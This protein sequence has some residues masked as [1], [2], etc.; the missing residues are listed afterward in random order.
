MRRDLPS[1]LVR[2]RVLFNLIL[3]LDGL[4]WKPAKRN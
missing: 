4:Y 2:C 3:I 1:P